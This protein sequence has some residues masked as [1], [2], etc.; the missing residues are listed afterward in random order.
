MAKFDISSGSYSLTVIN[1]K[2]PPKSCAL[3]NFWSVC[4]KYEAK[5][6]SGKYNYQRLAN[7]KRYFLHSKYGTQHDELEPN[8]KNILHR[9]GI[10]GLVAFVMYIVEN[11]SLK[12][13]DSVAPVKKSQNLAFKIHSLHTYVVLWLH[14]CVANCNM[15]QIEKKAFIFILAKEK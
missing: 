1:Q 10:W 6:Y 15:I 4:I 2:V 3:L 11:S 12:K 9:N 13:S 5:V 8:L 7:T 14:W